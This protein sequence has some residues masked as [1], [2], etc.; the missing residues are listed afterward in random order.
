MCAPYRAE[1]VARPR[2]RAAA[3]RARVKSGRV[4]TAGRLLIAATNW[5]IEACVSGSILTKPPSREMP[6]R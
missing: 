4:E 5:T 6:L 2:R 3:S 1:L